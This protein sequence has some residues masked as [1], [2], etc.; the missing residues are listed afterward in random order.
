MSNKEFFTTHDYDS[1]DDESLEVINKKKQTQ[2]EKAQLDPETLA[3]LKRIEPYNKKAEQLLKK[4][5]IRDYK[6]IL[7]ELN[8]LASDL[9]K[10]KKQ[11][12]SD[13]IPDSFFFVVLKIDEHC[14]GLTSKDKQ[15]FSKDAKNNMTKLKQ[16]ARKL[17]D[18]MN[19]KFVEYQKNPISEI[20]ETGTPDA[21]EEES[22]EEDSDSDS[23]DDDPSKKGDSNDEDG[24]EESEWDVDPIVEDVVED[25]NR[26]DDDLPRQERRKKW[27]RPIPLSQLRLAEEAKKKE[28]GLGVQDIKGV[29]RE[30]GARVQ[31][32]VYKVQELNQDFSGVDLSDE[33]VNKRLNDI[34]QNRT[35]F[36]AEKQLFNIDL[37]TYILNNLQEDKRRLEVIILL[38]YLKSEYNASQNILIDSTVWDE[39]LEFIDEYYNI[40]LGDKDYLNGRVR[41]YLKAERD[42][43]YEKREIES[44]FLSL[45]TSLDNDWNLLIKISDPETI[46]YSHLLKDEIR[47]TRI[48]RNCFEYFRKIG[49]TGSSG[50]IAAKLIE[51]IYFVSDDTIKLIKNTSP[52]YVLSTEPEGYICI[53]SSFVYNKLADS[54]VVTKTALLESFNHSIN[55]RYLQAKDLLLMFNLAEKLNS[56]T[57]L[58]VL[59]NRAL[60]SLGLCA[61]RL[62][63]VQD[64]QN[65]L[66]DLCNSGKLKELLSQTSLKGYGEIEEKRPIMPYHLSLSIESIETAYYIS[67]MLIECPVLAAQLN[68]SERRSSCKLFQRLWQHYEKNPLSGPPE[69]HRDIVYCSTKE[70]LRGEWSNCISL[71]N[72]LKIWTKIPNPS[73]V[74]QIYVTHVKQQAFKTFIASLKNTFHILKFERLEQIFDIPASKLLLLTCEMIHNDDIQAKLDPV[75]GCLITGKKDQNEFISVAEKLN[76]KAYSSINLNEKVFDVRLADLNFSEQISLSDTIQTRVQKKPKTGLRIFSN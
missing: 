52:D 34:G 8:S 43:L 23:S 70:L 12:D 64:C 65:I 44:Y 35:Q 11:F 5:Q 14:E 60:T 73:E 66:E 18:E 28:A 31:E 40:L 1:S 50:F 19:E 9:E 4:L 17:I 33:S 49:N 59:Y 36:T 74:K 39:V 13:G 46:E 6:E 22:S 56:D 7:N 26:K 38:I 63:R 67:V 2:A 42:Q 55:G 53:L 15:R 41:C 25:F 47:L 48:M 45:V 24:Q 30:Q 10:N 16:R 32:R 57:Y 20:E 51:H 27:L 72:Q 75:S 61:F 21:S 62:G 71:I 69:N 37:L 76:Q 68:D 58:S 54:S 3:K 29:K